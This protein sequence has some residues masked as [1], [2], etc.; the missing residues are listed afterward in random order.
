M[1]GQEQAR[2]VRRSA[3]L[4]HLDTRGV[5]RVAGGDRER[6]LNGMISNDVAALAPGPERSGCYA[7]LLTRK[8]LIL[9]DLQVMLRPE[10]YLLELARAAVGEILDCLERHIIADDVTVEDAS[11]EFERLGLEGPGARSLLAAAGSD[12]QLA[13]DACAE[14]SIAGVVVVTVAFGWSGE[15]AY[16]LL[17][18]AG[19]R[20]VVAEAIGSAANPGELVA[21]GAE[22]LEILRIEAGVPLLGAELSDDVFP[23]EARL[24]RAISTTK[25]CY[26]GQ[27]IVARLRSRGHVNHLLV[28]L[29]FPGEEVPRPGTE[30]LAEGRRT[31]EVTSCCTSPS[32]GPIGLGF[33]R[34]THAAPGTE[35]RAGDAP[36]RV[37]GLPFA[38]PGSQEASP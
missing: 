23:D 28:G 16:Q 7:T 9:A 15:N 12:P 18:P 4:F 13:P 1:N 26:T 6:W 14:L 29:E 19:Q 22:A 31:G 24:E 30:L 8:G 37:A 27:E 17:V 21:A 35:L 10:H 11:Q 3:G 34:R 20:E 25:G 5:I 2:A 36:A 33:V 32:A 38:G